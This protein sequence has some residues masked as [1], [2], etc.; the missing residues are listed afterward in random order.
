M[1][2]PPLLVLSAVLWE[3]CRF[4]EEREFW[5]ERYEYE[6]REFKFGLQLAAHWNT[7]MKKKEQDQQEDKT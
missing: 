5:R 1:E 7:I 6:Q 4:E 2:L 3:Q